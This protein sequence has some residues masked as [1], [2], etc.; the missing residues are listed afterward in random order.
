MGTSGPIIVTPPPPPPNQK[1]LLG[2]MPLT[3]DAGK[4]MRKASTWVAALSACL[5]VTAG[6]A[7][8][9]Y[10][11]L[12][13]RAQ[14]LVSDEYLSLLSYTMIASAAVVALVPVATSWAQ[15]GFKR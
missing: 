4:V 11:T 13:S 3:Q 15:A 10:V 8:G 12:P 1:R 6:A 14:S 9:A 7:L 2:I 5:S